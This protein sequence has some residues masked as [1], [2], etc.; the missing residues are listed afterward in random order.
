MISCNQNYD[1]TYCQQ[2]KEGTFRALELEMI[3]TTQPALE[4]QSMPAFVVII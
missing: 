2:Q 3:K 1:I 4:E